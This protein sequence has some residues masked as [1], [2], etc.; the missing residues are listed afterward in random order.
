MKKIKEKVILSKNEAASAAKKMMRDSKILKIIG[1][2]NIFTTY[3]S[4]SLFEEF[5]NSKSDI[6]IFIIVDEFNIK[7]IQS[8]AESDEDFTFYDRG[9]RKVLV[10]TKEEIDFDIEIY[11]KEYILEYISMVSLGTAKNHDKRYDIFHRLKFAK[12]LINDSNFGILKAKMEYDKFSSLFSKEYRIYY[13]VRVTDILGAYQEEKFDTSFKMA[14][15]LLESG[16]TAYLSLA[17]ETNPSS[18][19]LMK[20]IER[21]SKNKKETDLNLFDMLCSA[22]QNIELNNMELLKKKT[23]QILTNCQLLNLKCEEKSNEN[24]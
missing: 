5:G 7:K 15:D 10:T 19:W 2:E 18:K 23:I 20:K 9:L 4:G 21:Y 16:I 13:G 6:D 8:I 1:E 22:Y 11:E 14:L 24:Y 3:V 12:Q 17:E